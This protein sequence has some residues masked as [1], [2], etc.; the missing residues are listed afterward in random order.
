MRIAAVVVTYNRLQFLQKVILS[1][2]KQSVTVSDI[3]VVNN[4]STDGTADWLKVQKELVVINQENVGG[5]GGFYAGI[6]Y[7]HR[8]GYDYFWC[9]DDDV[10]PRPDCLERLV[11]AM[12]D[13]VGITCPKRIQGDHLFITESITLNL[14]NPWKRLFCNKLYAKHVHNKPISIEGMVFEGP[15][16]KMAVVNDIGYPNKD[17]FLFFDDFDYSYRAVLSG[18]K[19]LYVPKACLD[20]ESFFNTLSRRDIF[21]KNRWKQEYRI[22]NYAYFN[23]Y[24]GKG[25]IIKKLR[26]FLYVLYRYM[27]HVIYTGEF[28]AFDSYYRAY[29]KGI[30]GVLGKI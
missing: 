3:I 11:N 21:R 15:L 1:L 6:E 24:Y 16:I 12:T 30:D 23:N 13:E 19:V 25:C 20:K 8:R 9:M 17:L 10:Y 26:P 29:Q 27:E 22:R 14:T 5:S 2:K 7:A 4:G 28:K 18:F